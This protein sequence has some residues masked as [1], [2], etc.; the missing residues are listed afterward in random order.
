MPDELRDRRVFVAN[1][2]HVQIREVFRRRVPV[3]IQT[4]IKRPVASVPVQKHAVIRRAV[5]NLR[6]PHFFDL[7]SAPCGNI[8]NLNGICPGGR[9]GRKC[10]F[11]ARGI[12]CEFRN[13]IARCPVF[14]AGYGC[15]RL[16][17]KYKIRGSAV[18][19]KPHAAFWCQLVH[20]LQLGSAARRRGIRKHNRNIPGNRR[21]RTFAASPYLILCTVQN[22]KLFRK[23][24]K[25]RV[26]VRYGSNLRNRTLRN[27]HGIQ[28]PACGNHG[29]LRSANVAMPCPVDITHEIVQRFHAGALFQ[30]AVVRHTEIHHFR[31]F[32]HFQ[33][34]VSVTGL[35]QPHPF[36]NGKDF[37]LCR[38]CNLRHVKAS[39][40]A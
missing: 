21:S 24:E 22:V 16:F 7:C 27:V 38:G 15:N 36:L 20:G 28:L 8:G 35:I 4:G 1:V 34:C 39:P 3:I 14:H 17:W 33:V 9:S 12:C 11:P 30:C 25:L 40:P 10:D 2:Q 5:V 31:R 26:R 18:R 37:F 13:R 6:K 23:P 19:R 29:I 32:A